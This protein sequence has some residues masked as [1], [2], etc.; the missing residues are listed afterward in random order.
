MD[1]IADG[2]IKPDII[3]GGV[4]DWILILYYEKKRFADSAAVLLPFAT[5]ENFKEAL[6]EYIDNAVPM[7]QTSQKQDE[8]LAAKFNKYL[9]YFKEK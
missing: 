2:T 9:G 1:M 3:R 6:Q 8:N 7:P 5:K 4:T